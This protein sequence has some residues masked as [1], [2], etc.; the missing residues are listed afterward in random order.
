MSR[1]ALMLPK[2]STY[3][4]VEGFSYRLAAALADEGYDVDFLCARQETRAPAGVSAVVLGRPPLGR[5][6]K[7][8]WFAHAAERAR[9]RGGYDLTLSMGKTAR[10]DVLRM[11]GGPLAKFWELSRRAYAPGFERGFKMLRRRT[12]PANMLIRSL[13]RRGLANQRALATVSHRVLDWLYE[14]HPFLR[15]RDVRVIYNKPDLAR[16]SPMGESERLRTRRAAGV[17]GDRPL[18]FIAGTNFALKGVGPLIRALPHIP[19]E[20][21]LYVAGGRNPGRFK[22]LAARLG[23]EDRVAFLGRVKDMAALYNACDVFCL[24]SFYDTCANAVVEALACGT[25][26]V[27]SRDNGSSYFLS[28]ERVVDD[29]ADHLTLARAVEDALSAPRPGRFHWPEDVASGLPP[30]LDMVR[31]LLRG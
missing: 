24:P 15:E 2:L 13:E 30:Y 7:I 17:D 8:A 1:L 26:V 21:L 5:A 11:S 14:A 20:P 10:Q 31:D 27:S 19:G 4:G 23:V 25:R 28:P 16:F 18:I 12:A 22:A 3:G 6:A 9:K 29:P